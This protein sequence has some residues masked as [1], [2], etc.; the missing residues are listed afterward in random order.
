MSRD[1]TEAAPLAG[2]TGRCQRIETKASSTI[3]SQKSPGEWVRARLGKT[4]SA[5]VT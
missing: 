4:H 5:I 3:S 1:S 2:L